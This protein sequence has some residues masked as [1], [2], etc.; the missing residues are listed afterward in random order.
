MKDRQIINY[1]E[2]KHDDL[3]KTDTQLAEEYLKG[4]LLEQFLS[5]AN[6]DSE[7]KMSLKPMQLVSYLMLND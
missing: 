4:Q 7:I 2:L 1:Y 5:F 3:T 6:N